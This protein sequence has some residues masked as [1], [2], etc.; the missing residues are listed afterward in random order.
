M[1]KLQKKKVDQIANFIIN[2]ITYAEVTTMVV[3]RAKA[4]AEFIVENELDPKDFNSSVSRKKLH[5]KIEI[6]GGKV[7]VKEEE[8]WDNNILNKVGLGDKKE[9]SQKSTKKFKTK[10][11]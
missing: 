4:L 3:E 9:E 2:N 8:A 1:D 5:K 11:R 7:K 6:E 10:K